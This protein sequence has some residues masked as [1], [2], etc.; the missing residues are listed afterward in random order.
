M[1]SRIAVNRG[2][3]RKRGSPACQGEERRVR[4]VEVSNELGPG[5]LG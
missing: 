4:V 2:Q 3:N 5:W 1:R